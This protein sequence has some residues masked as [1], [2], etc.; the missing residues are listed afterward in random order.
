ME[1]N[2]QKADR[3]GGLG[4]PRGARPANDGS[5]DKRSHKGSQDVAANVSATQWTG[6]D[7]N[8]QVWA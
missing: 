5:P 4:N 8:D 7:Q 2:Q 1:K 6:W 3:G